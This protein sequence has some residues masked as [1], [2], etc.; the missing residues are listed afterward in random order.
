MK[1]A[2][3][4]KALNL[5]KQAKFDQ[6]FKALKKHAGSS[7]TDSAIWAKL[8]SLCGQAGL[9]EATIQCCQRA[10]QADPK[11]AS[12]YSSMGNALLAL[13]HSEQALE[14][15]RRAVALMP[16]DAAMHF[17]YAV[18]LRSMASYEAAIKH[19]QA[20]L[21]LRPDDAMAHHM[22]ATC[23][24][25]TGKLDLL[26]HHYEESLRLKPDLH[27]SLVNLG[28]H[29]LNMGEHSRSMQYF[30]AALDVSPAD[31]Q[32]FA[33]KADVLLHL[34]DKEEAYVYVR[35][36]IDSGNPPATAL[37]VYAGLYKQFG[38][39]QELIKLASV[40]LNRADL[41]PIEKSNLGF[42]LGKIYDADGDYDQAFRYYQYANQASF[43]SF[44]AS[45]HSD[46]VQ[47]I[48]DTYSSDFVA[49]MKKGISDD[50]LIFIFGMP[51]SGTTLTEQI[52]SRHSDVFACGESLIIH[53]LMDELPKFTSGAGYPEAVTQI[54]D[55][56]WLAREVQQRY[57]ALSGNVARVTD[58]LP[59]NYLR[60]GLLSQLFPNAKFVHC[61]R[62]PRDVCLS[63]YFQNF[64]NFQPYAANL[65]HI[66]AV[67]LQYHRLMQ[68]WREALDVPILDFVY[69][70]L[71]E[72]F[73]DGVRGLLHFC[74]LEWQDA[75][76]QFHKS[77]RV[78][79]TASFDQ[80]NKP[81]YRRSR[82]RWKNYEKHIG[83][84][85]ERL[86][87]IL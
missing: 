2:K 84:L 8:G 71:V 47:A 49:S 55:V 48:I 86:A 24:Q 5:L 57:E 33:G 29:Y 74:G 67:Y 30:D 6:A 26:V 40:M 54:S 68:H 77:E 85:L 16:D 56:K 53:N 83:V 32:A 62:D 22:L 75:C 58:K 79:S 20:T 7:V 52:L 44:D 42:A 66:A 73:E 36:A 78:A 12:A 31:P 65:E 34:G 3:I 9:F 69:E 28:F 10:L 37:S 19:Y 45:R 82:A 1:K 60:I 18:A 15:S 43:A 70:D 72:N 59:A 13:G 35:K 4:Q 87:D 63:I 76:L 50:K 41:T 17:N 25:A 21:A 23:Y 46:Q 38:D 64:Q 51:R 61:V 80:V 14:V 11:N 39:R 27:A 81:L